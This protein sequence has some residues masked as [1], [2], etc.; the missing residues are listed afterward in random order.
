MPYEKSEVDPAPLRRLG[1]VVVRRRTVPGGTQEQLAHAAGISVYF[2]RRIERGVGNP[3]YMTLRR[4][5]AALGTDVA[6][7]IAEAEKPDA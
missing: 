7:L 4:L 2:L 6:T 3:S 5:A 1:D